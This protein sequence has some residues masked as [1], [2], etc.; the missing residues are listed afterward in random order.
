MRSAVREREDRRERRE[1]RRR[2]SAALLLCSFLL[3]FFFRK[4]VAADRPR[5]LSA[6]GTCVFCETAWNFVGKFILRLGFKC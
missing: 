1:E 5:V 2:K 3:F 4:V 6:A